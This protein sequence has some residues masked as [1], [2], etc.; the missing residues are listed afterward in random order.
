LIEFV[1]DNEFPRKVGI[2]LEHSTHDR[3]FDDFF[4]TTSNVFVWNWKSFKGG[5]WSFLGLVGYR[6]GTNP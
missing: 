6:L 4:S 2:V 1:H 3:F 5:G